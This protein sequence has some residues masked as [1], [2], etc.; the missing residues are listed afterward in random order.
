MRAF[1]LFA[2]R[3]SIKF[4]LFELKIKIELLFA[5]DQIRLR[6]DDRLDAE[7]APTHWLTKTGFVSG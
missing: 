1:Q 2:M 5:M 7:R 4:Q 6:S 3:L